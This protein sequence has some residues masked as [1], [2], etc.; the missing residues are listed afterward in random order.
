MV[1]L[2]ELRRKELE[3]CKDNLEYFVLNYGHIENKDS[4][5]VIIPFRLWDAQRKC[6][7]TFETDR[8]VIVLKARQLGFTWLALHYIAWVM[9]NPGRTAIGI[10]ENEDKAKELIRRI[11]YV[12]FA[13]MPELVAPKGTLGWKGLWFESNALS[14]T[15]HHPDGPDSKFECFPSSPNAG[16]SF[17]ADVLLFDEW[18]FQ[19]F[20]REI[21]GSAYATINRATSGQIIGISSIK[22]GSLF[23]ELFTS[24]SN[25]Y[26]KVFIPWHADPSRDAEWYEDTKKN[27]SDPVLMTAEYPATVEE[28]LT[29]PGG[30]FFPEVT[31]DLITNKGLEGNV[32]TYFVMDYGLDML[33]AYWIQRDAFG[34]SQIIY[35]HC[36]PNLSIPVAAEKIRNI[37]NRIF[38]GEKGRFDEWHKPVL[39]LAPPDLWNRGQETGKSRAL[40]FGEE[41]LPLTKVNND[42]AA[43]CAAIKTM[44]AKNQL[45]ILNNCAPVLMKCLKKIQR[46]E[47]RPNIYAN[48]PHDLTHSVDG[49]RYFAIYWLQ[50]AD[51]LLNSK[52]VKWREDQW[53]DYDNASDSDK[54]LLIKKWGE[55]A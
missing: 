32:I 30:A 51:S 36:E 25:S 13:Y 47:N 20:D 37:T 35:E 4:A 5:E 48:K 49:I 45:S 19:Q 46:D 50:N 21:Y 55:P 31:D 27:L 2:E 52:K 28:A 12:I 53:E 39:Y 44:L 33:A 8:R 43:G 54:L 7:K 9:L 14:C 24:E 34:N 18:A 6:L 1:E 3:Y 41:G 40:I 29:I 17:T 38:S 11:A 16:R 42:I 26:T 23:E 15:I 10:S 22:R